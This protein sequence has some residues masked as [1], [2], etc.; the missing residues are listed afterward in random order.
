[1][2]EHE[3]GEQ[4]ARRSLSAA[5][6]EEEEEEG[7]KQ[8]GEEG[9]RRSRRGGGGGACVFDAF[10]LTDSPAIAHRGVLLDISRN[11]VPTPAAARDLAGRVQVECS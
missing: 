1:M 5:Q 6:E 11:R 2:D 4:G 7:K 10:T 9:M 3:E 8:K